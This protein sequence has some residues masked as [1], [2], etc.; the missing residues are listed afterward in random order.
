M[1]NKTVT[2]I[3]FIKRHW[4][5]HSQTRCFY[6]VAS[7]RQEHQTA[8]NVATVDLSRTNDNLTVYSYLQK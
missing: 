2:W 6:A 3:R 7:L 5:G 4:L 8:D 1:F